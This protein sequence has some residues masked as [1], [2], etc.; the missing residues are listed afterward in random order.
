MAAKENGGIEVSSYDMLNERKGYKIFDA[1]ATS[2]NFEML[3]KDIATEFR[4]WAMLIHVY[5]TTLSKKYYTGVAFT[6]PD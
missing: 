5:S 6:M 3:S 4:G 2:S 1:Y